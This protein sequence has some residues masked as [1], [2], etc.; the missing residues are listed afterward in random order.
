MVL[1]VSTLNKIRETK[2]CFP[3][4]SSQHISDFGVSKCDLMGICVTIIQYRKVK[5]K[6]IIELST[7]HF[8]SLENGAPLVIQY[9]K[10]KIKI[11]IELGTAHFSSLENGAPLVIQY[12]K[13]KIKIIIELGTA[14]FS[15]LENGAPL[16]GCVFHDYNV[17]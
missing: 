10:D 13:D 12:R 1:M 4:L 5:I 8:S 11:I 7:A 6:I 16:V 2:I 3:F 14:H 15:S 9:R 17:R